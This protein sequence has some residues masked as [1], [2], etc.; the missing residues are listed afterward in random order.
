MSAE[1]WQRL[2][3]IFDAG[4]ALN[5][6]DRRGFLA[7]AC[8]D[9]PDLLAE[10]ERLFAAHEQAGDFIESPALSADALRGL[11]QAEVGRR[12]GAYRMLRGD[13]PRRHGRGLP[14]RA[15]RRTVPQAG[16]A[17]SSSS[18]GWTPT[19]V[20]RRFRAERQILASLDHPNIARLLD[21]GTTDDGLPYFVMEYI[22][23]EPIDEYSDAQRSRSTERL[24]AVPPGLRRGRLRASAPRRPPRHQAANI[25][26][27]AD[28]VPKLLDFGI[29]KVL[30]DRRRRDAD[31]R[32]ALRLLTPGVRQPRAGARGATP[33]TASDV[34]SLGVVLYEL[35]TGRSPY[36]L[37]SR[38]PQDIA[39]AVCTTEPDA[40][41]PRRAR[42]RTASMAA[43][44]AAARCGRPRHHRAHRARK[45]PARR[46]QSVEQFADDIRRHLDG[47]PVRARPDTFGYRAGEVRPAATGPASP[48]ARLVALALDRRHRW[49]RPGRPAR[50]GAAQAR[51]ERRFNDVRK[52][53]NALSCSTI[54]TPSRTW[55]GATPGPPPAGPRRPGY[56]DGLAREAHGDPSLQRE[57]ARPTVG[58]ATS[59]AGIPKA[60][61]TPKAPWRATARHCKCSTR[62]T[63]RIPITS[64]S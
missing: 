60:S 45:E 10:V 16:R 59:R 61:A 13:R 42:P 4:V 40:P 44:A 56:L 55:R 18:A 36:R 1:R 24:R 26:V 23:G 64:P 43:R 7:H 51:A 14:G 32:P 6:A 30:H 9:D 54:T 25:L 47:L 34:Y 52:L 50:R 57:L 29:A 62:C 35:L 58:S 12:I 15:R 63:A 21:G 37:T 38:S 46:Y 31:R 22:E 53:A 8:A 11:E 39:V 28:G 3:Y 19:Q 27:T 5:P 49:R 48:P 20:L 41:A 17:S 33:P 2:T